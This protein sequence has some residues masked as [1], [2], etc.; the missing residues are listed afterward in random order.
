MDA[1]SPAGLS[2]ALTLSGTSGALHSAMRDGQGVKATVVQIDGEG[3]EGGQLIIRIG[4]ERVSARSSLALQ[5]GDRLELRVSRSPQRI[6]LILTSI[7]GHSASLA[8]PRLDAAIRRMLP[9]QTGYPVLLELLNGADPA[10]GEK[11]RSPALVRLATGLLSHLPTASQLSSA[12]GVRSAW[13]NSGLFLESRL[14]TGL[15][16]GQGPSLGNDLKGLLLLL[17]EGLRRGHTE[18]TTSGTDAG[19]RPPAQTAPAATMSR[20]PRAELAKA[21]EGNLARLGLHQLSVARSHEDGTPCW[22]FE[23]P[24]RDGERF[25][26][27]RF[28]IERRPRRR[29]GQP[30][31]LALTIDLD[32]PQTGPVKVRLGLVDQRLSATLWAQRET[33]VSAIRRALPRLGAMLERKGLAP[34]TLACH[35][36]AGPRSRLHIAHGPTAGLDL[37]A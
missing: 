30:D 23:L 13:L 7:N 10:S 19:S 9:V 33:T 31:S 15:A 16:P 4:S 1:L 2:S 37:K 35:H 26:V 22:A 24:V 11:A 3:P 29:P 18:R 25:D 12:A 32:L 20:D 28:E 5:V 14:A 21:V 6:T 17:M 27:L 36:G 8:A 34:D